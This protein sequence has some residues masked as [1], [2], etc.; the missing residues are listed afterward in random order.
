MNGFKVETLASFRSTAEGFKF[1]SGRDFS[2]S[3]G[4]N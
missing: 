1:I 3:P 2:D 4:L